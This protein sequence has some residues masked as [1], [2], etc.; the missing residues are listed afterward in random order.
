MPE[1][2][3]H[4]PILA[5]TISSVPV[6]IDGASERLKDLGVVVGDDDRAPGAC[7][8]PVVGGRQAS[9]SAGSRA[10]A[11]RRRRR[12][13][14]DRRDRLLR[15]DRRAPGR[16]RTGAAGAGTT[17]PACLRPSGRSRRSMSPARGSAKRCVVGGRG[18]S[19]QTRLA[20]RRVG[21]YRGGL[22]GSVD[23]GRMRQQQARPS[24][25][26]S[27]M[28]RRRAV[29]TPHGSRMPA[30]ARRLPPGRA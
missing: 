16:H 25:M 22:A 2:P 7:V 15:R 26:P 13:G 12:S 8:H 14:V 29:P 30:S 1:T 17:A 10:R 21:R 11:D 20:A 24:P 3:V 23:F 6:A 5:S 9:W 28:A 18:I 19:Q 4:A 27:V